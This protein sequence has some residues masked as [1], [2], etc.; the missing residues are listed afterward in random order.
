MSANYTKSGF[1]AC[2]IL[3]S[4]E[5]DLRLT[6][7]A[8]STAPS[9]FLKTRS[10]PNLSLSSNWLNIGVAHIISYIAQH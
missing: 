4:A 6:R 3:Q 5:S 9:D 1:K 8:V 2:F 10:F 7:L